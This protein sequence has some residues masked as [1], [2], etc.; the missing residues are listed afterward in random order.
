[1]AKTLLRPLALL[2][3]ASVATLASTAH[4]QV[5]TGA[6]PHYSVE[7]EPRLDFNPNS[8]FSYGGTGIG[9]GVRA[10][11]PVMS[12]GFI[13]SI[14]DSVAVTFGLDLMSYSGYYYYG[15]CDR[16]GCPYYDAGHFW[17]L[18]FPLAAQWNFWLTDKWSVFG[19]LG[20]AFRHAFW[21]DAYCDP[22]YYSCGSRDDLYL[23]IAGGGRY[24]FSDKFGLTMRL[25]HPILLEIG[26]SIFF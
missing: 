20:L 11:I 10:S 5:G 3:G 17:A 4:A 21:S 2:A 18:Y 7:L 9:A 24:K 1:M 25:G 12:P 6:P 19:E 23:E 8:V 15:P 16:F 26:L 13:P 14:N 22:R